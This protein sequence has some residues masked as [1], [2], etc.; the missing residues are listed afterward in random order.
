MKICLVN[1]TSDDNNWGAK[2]TSFALRELVEMAGG[3]VVSTIYQYHI[4]A[5]HKND[6]GKR[7]ED[8][9]R[10]RCS[11]EGNDILDVAPTSWSDFECS[12]RRVMCGDI[13]GEI[14]AAISQCDVVLINGEG[15]IYDRTRQSRMIYFIAFLA[16]KY[17][18]KATALVNHSV[19]LNDPVVN[20][21]AHQVNP[22][23]D[24]VVFREPD[25][26]LA[27][28]EG[29]GRIAADA[30]YFYPHLSTEKNIHD[31]RAKSLKKLLDGTER[32]DPMK[33]Y[34]CVGGGSVYFRGLKP[35]FDPTPGLV[36][37]C[38]KLHQK[39]GQVL[40]TASSEKDMHL[41]GSV[42]QELELPFIKN[43]VSTQQAIDVLG[44][45]QAYIGARW[46]PSI[47][48]HIGGVPV[49]AI[50]KHTPKMDAFMKQAGMKPARFDPFSL[51]G[52]ADLIVNE[53]ENCIA[54]GEG[55]RKKLREGALR[56]KELSKESVRLLKNYSHYS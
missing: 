47:F 10:A 55:L 51:G 54:E 39:T 31:A 53:V 18:G 30:A 16:K 41:M 23:L 29:H 27:C 5:P 35:G 46:H 45:A 34:V 33:P 14:K 37:L 2:A 6:V 15:C 8:I 32:F 25:S 9:E 1:D 36:S 52:Q 7:S 12:A 56:L 40:L 26:A 48:A 20:E 38:E 24:D 17:F 42:S 28:Q 44:N 43:S 49:I 4:S 50:S 21:I 3:C 22:M 19:V 11:S 13:F